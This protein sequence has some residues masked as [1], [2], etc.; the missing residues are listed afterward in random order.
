MRCNYISIEMEENKETIAK[1]KKKTL[2]NVELL[3]LWISHT[4]G[5]NA[6]WSRFSGIALGKF[7]MHLTYAYVVSGPYCTFFLEKKKNRKT[8]SHTKILH[9]NVH[10]TF[11]CNSRKLEAKHMSFN[12]EWIK[13]YYLYEVTLYPNKKKGHVTPYNLNQSQGHISEKRS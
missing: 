1:P 3:D 8:S 7:L 2:R 11:I 4:H 10:R 6:E 12:E 5:E 13:G 9:L